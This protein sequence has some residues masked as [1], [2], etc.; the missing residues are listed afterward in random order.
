MH[1]RGDFRLPPRPYREDGAARKVGFELEFSGITQRQAVEAVRSAMGGEVLS[2]TS[3]ETRLE[4]AGLGPFNIELDWAYL[5][6][7]AGEAGRGEIDGEWIEHLS[8]AA[9][10]LVPVEVVCPPI[11][12]TELESLNALT[13]ALHDAGATGTEE[14]FIAAYG[15]HINPEI[16]RLDAT[17]L[18]AYI[19]AFAA[20]QWWLFDAHEVDMS[21][22]ISPY[23]DPYPDAYLKQVLSRSSASMDQIFDDYFAYNATRNR[24]LDLL[25]MLAEVDE[26]RVRQTVDDP[27]V[28]AR[29][30]FHYRLP[31]CHIERDDWG[32]ADSWNLWCVV[33][34]VADRR[35]DLRELADAFSNADRPL[36]GVSRGDWVRFMDQW[37]RDRELV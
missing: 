13:Q 22:R 14:S 10:L 11:P 34:R 33:E 28:K 30:A 20:L 31:N 6:R 25:P 17:T 29:P 12:I 32:L 1:D 19:Q 35:D 18:L 36:L 16:P 4:V 23:I 37:L 2:E 15:V 27:K 9:S 26:K 21:R 8:S 3:A 24:A 5:K 7:K